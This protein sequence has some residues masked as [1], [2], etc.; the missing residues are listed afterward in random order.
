MEKIALLFNEKRSLSVF[1]I[2]KTSCYQIWQGMLIQSSVE[3]YRN[4]ILKG[5]IKITL[6]NGIFKKISKY[7]FINH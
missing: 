2:S 1:A 7:F 6:K 5:I 4:I 3:N